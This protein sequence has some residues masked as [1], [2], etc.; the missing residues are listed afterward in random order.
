MEA[1]YNQNRSELMKGKKQFSRSAEVPETPEYRCGGEEASIMQA[2]AGG[3]E[4]R[5][6]DVEL[7]NCGHLGSIYET[8]NQRHTLLRAFVVQG[9]KQHEK[10]ILIKD[11]LTGRTAP[12]HAEFVGL[13]LQPWMAPGQLRVLTTLQTFLRQGFFDP[14]RVIAWLQRETRK[15]EAEGYCALRVA[16]D[17]TWALRGIEGS[18]KLIEYETALDAF[19]RGRPCRILCQYD[20]RRFPPAVLQHAL[21]THPTVVVRGAVCRNSYYRIAP[22]GFGDGPASATL[23]R[24]LKDLSAHNL[25]MVP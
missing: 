19:L 3:A 25:A 5:D 21:T 10:I 11:E 14:R 15:A 8:D 23:G 6:A 22:S 18:E 7:P 12:N 2:E 9:L 1:T 17:M 4:V 20:A 13:D 24:W 16:A